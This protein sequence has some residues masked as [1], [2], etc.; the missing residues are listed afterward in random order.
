[1]ISRPKACAPLFFL[2]VNFFRFLQLFLRDFNLSVVHGP[3]EAGFIAL[4]AGGTGLLDLDEEHVAIAIKGD[5]FHDLHVAAFLPFHPEFLPRTAPEMRFAGGDSLFE[6]RT[7]HPCKHQDAASALLLNDSRDQTV[8]V[9]LQLVVKTHT[10]IS[11]KI[12]RA[13]KPKLQ[14]KSG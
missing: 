6:G 3:E 1:M 7:V 12:S 2:P 8:G 11:A 14:D 5:I 13:K 9:K 10:T 4:V